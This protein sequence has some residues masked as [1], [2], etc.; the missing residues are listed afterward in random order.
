MFKLKGVE[1]VKEI[2]YKFLN[3]IRCLENKCLKND[4]LTVNKTFIRKFPNNSP[5]KG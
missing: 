1:K 2:F 3:I 4:K 5:T